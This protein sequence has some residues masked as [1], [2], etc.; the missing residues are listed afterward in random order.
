VLASAGTLA[1]VALLGVPWS[2]ESGVLAFVPQLLACGM[3]VLA[4]RG[5]RRLVARLPAALV[6]LLALAFA[7]TFFVVARLPAPGTFETL[8]RAPDVRLAQAEG[9]S[10]TLSE[11][12]ARGP[13][14]LVFFRGHW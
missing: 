2:R 12:A 11:A 14:L 7:W 1:Y 5:D 6:G 4:W 8:A 13:V 9:G 3:A 10:L